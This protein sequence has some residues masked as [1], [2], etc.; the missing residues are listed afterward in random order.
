MLFDESLALST[1]VHR[2]KQL[3]T[4][5]HRSTHFQIIL[6]TAMQQAK[7]NPDASKQATGPHS[8]AAL[9]TKGR[10]ALAAGNATEAVRCFRLALDADDEHLE[11]HHGL[12]LALRQAGR[13]EQ[14]IAIALRW[15]ALA[16]KDA[17]AHREL[18]ESLRLA[19]HTVQAE[20]AA[21]RARV[22]EWKQ[23]LASPAEDPEP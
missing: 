15:T 22:L 14:S 2:Q 12:V 16:P 20:T 6:K 7:P 18:A 5:S 11:A 10:E 1:E 17:L 13:L 19:G 8:A 23:Q 3:H 9:Y 21:Q 4:V